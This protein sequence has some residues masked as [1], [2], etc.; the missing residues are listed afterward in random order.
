VSVKAKIIGGLVAILA[1]F[2]IGFVPQFTARR[3]LQADLS[4]TRARLAVAE[5]QIEIDE[6]R[7]LAG[8]MLLETSR[9]NYGNAREL[10]T[11][12]FNKVSELAE[13][14]EDPALQAALLKLLSARDSI[15]SALAQGN[16]SVVTELQAL[17]NDTYNAPD[18]GSV[19]R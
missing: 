10:S 4:E 6:I 12:Y 7:G 1:A 16:A 17:L 18:A 13:K 15:T 2:S 11:A 9:Q 8:R 19:A 14:T 5:R 3:R